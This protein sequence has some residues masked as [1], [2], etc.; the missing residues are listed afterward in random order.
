M[1]VARG[2][3]TQKPLLK[4]YSARDLDPDMISH[5]GDQLL[6]TWNTFGGQKW[7]K[8]AMVKKSKK[9]R[10]YP[11]HIGDQLLVSIKMAKFEREMSA[12]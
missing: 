5:I 11:T 12:E 4:I 8:S 7:T 2:G 6:L 9:L 3:S 10:A 1:V